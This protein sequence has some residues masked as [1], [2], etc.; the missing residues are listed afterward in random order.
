LKY[1][2]EDFNV[3]WTKNFA[4]AI[5]ICDKEGIITY[6][7]DQ[8]AV[9]FAN[10]GGYDL[11]GKSLFE[12]HLQ[13]SNDKIAEIMQTR[14]PHAYTTE[15]KGIKRLIYQ[16]PHIENGAV[17]GIVELAIEIPSDMPHYIRS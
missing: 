3:D 9:M 17:I 5:T 8:A 13:S 11:I 16:A 10:N 14:K 6:M 7:N 2:P 4:A 12:C 1:F 15:K